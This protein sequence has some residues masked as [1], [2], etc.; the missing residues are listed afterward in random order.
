[1]RLTTTTTK[2]IVKSTKTQTT[3]EEIKENIPISIRM[4]SCCMTEEYNR[5]LTVLI[6]KGIKA[7][8]NYK[9]HFTQEGH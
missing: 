1:M 7:D 8:H 4:I 6:I 2:K 5:Y 9:W 3:H